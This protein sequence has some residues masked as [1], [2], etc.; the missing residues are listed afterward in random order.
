MMSKKDIYNIGEY[1]IALSRVRYLGLV[2]TFVRDQKPSHSKSHSFVYFGIS[3]VS[4]IEDLD[5]DLGK[6]YHDSGFRS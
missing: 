3:V 2:Q 5:N 6:D 1:C 4:I